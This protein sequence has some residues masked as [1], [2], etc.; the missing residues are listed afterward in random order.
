MRQLDFHVSHGPPSLAE[1]VLIHIRRH[2]HGRI[3][4]L[5][6]EEDG[7]TLV[8][9]GES[10]TWHAKQLALQGV[11]EVLPDGRFSER[12]TVVDPI[13]ATH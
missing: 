9:S 13:F 2:A 5:T 1:Q 12:I 10:R 3:R 6:V 4:N 7:G 11:L 8:V